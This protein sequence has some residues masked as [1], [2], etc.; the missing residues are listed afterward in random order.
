MTH[1]TEWLFQINPLIKVN[2]KLCSS[3]SSPGP[4]AHVLQLPGV[5]YV[6]IPVDYVRNCQKDLGRAVC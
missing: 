1:A 5:M 4:T 3:S 2:I 6:Y